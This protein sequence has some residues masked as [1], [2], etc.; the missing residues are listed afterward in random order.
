MMQANPHQVILGRNL[1]RGETV[2][3]Y[4]AGDL[5]P[6]WTCVL[7]DGNVPF[8]PV[9]IP[10]R[11]KMWRDGVLLF[12]RPA[13]TLDHDGTVTLQLVAGDTDEPGP[14]MSKVVCTKPGSKPATFPPNGFMVT[15]IHPAAP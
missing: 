9:G 5:D 11:V 6:P 10:T 13:T 12:D 8:D 4:T 1:H 15:R 2:D 14:L 7:H 3:S